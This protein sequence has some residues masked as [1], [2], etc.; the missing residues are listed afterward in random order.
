MTQKTLMILITLMSG[1]DGVDVNIGDDGYDGNTDR[2][3]DGC[4]G[5]G[6][7][8]YDDS[9]VDGGHTSCHYMRQT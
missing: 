5:D 3:D 1:V 8:D 9:C 6:C 2:C 4:G 7:V